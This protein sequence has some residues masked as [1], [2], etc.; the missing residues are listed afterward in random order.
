MQLPNAP[1]QTNTLQRSPLAGEVSLGDT[2]GATIDATLTENPTNSLQDVYALDKARAT[3]TER[4][5]RED[6]K[7][8]IEFGQ[9]ESPYVSITEQQRRLKDLNL[10][11]QLE[12]YEGE[13][14]AGFEMRVQWRQDEL[15]RQTVFK[16][17]SQGV[18]TTLASFGVGLAGSILDPLNIASGFIPV[19]GPARYAKML[20]Q[21][22]SAMGRAAVRARVGAL[23]G[24]VGGAVV[25]PL[26]IAGAD[27]RSADY[28]VYDS[29]AN[30][31]FGTIL[32]GGL[33][34]GGGFLSDTIEG[35]R[36]SASLDALPAEKRAEVL[37][38]GIAAVAEGRKPISAEAVARAAVQSD[39]KIRTRL[40]ERLAQATE[41]ETLKVAQ[42]LQEERI[43]L[44]TELEAAQTELRAVQEN[45]QTIASDAVKSQ[46]PEAFARLDV[47]DATLEADKDLTT[48]RSLTKS[49][50]KALVKERDE[51]RARIS[52]IGTSAQVKAVE[53]AIK[54]PTAKI[55][56][57]TE[58]LAD[59]DRRIQETMTKAATPA[60]GQPPPDTPEQ[61]V[62]LVEVGRQAADPSNKVFSDIERRYVEA[63]KALDSRKSDDLDAIRA[64]IDAAMQDLS[65]SLGV[66]PPAKPSPK[67][68]KIANDIERQ[69]VE[70]G[71]DPE[72]AKGE[73]A[74]HG[75][76]AHVLE[77]QYGVDPATVY[78]N[79]E[80]VQGVANDVVDK[81]LLAI[82]QSQIQD[83]S[84]R[85]LVSQGAIPAPEARDIMGLL[86]DR[87]A[88][89][90][91]PSVRLIKDRS[92]MVWA[93][94]AYTMTHDDIGEILGELIPN[95][96]R[97]EIDS[98][99]EFLRLKRAGDLSV[100]SQPNTFDQ[101]ANGTTPYA[102]DRITVDGIERTT[103]N[104]K[105]QPIAQTKEGLENFWKWFG[106][107]AVKDDAGKPLVVYHGSKSDIEI[108]E[109]SR[110]GEFGS[111][112]YF[113][114]F[115]PTAEMFGDMSRGDGGTTLYPAYISLK[116][117]LIT[118]DRNVPRGAGVKKLK[119]Q[120]YDGV[121]GIGPTGQKQY[122]VFDPEQ[123]K[124]IHNRGTFDPNDARILYQSKIE[125]DT[126]TFSADV[127]SF[128]RG[129]IAKD[130]MLRVGDTPDILQLAG[131]PNKP[132]RMSQKVARKVLA[133]TSQDSRHALRPETLSD[134]PKLLA[135]PLAVMTSRTRPDDS[136]VVLLD[137]T[138]MEGGQIVATIVDT[139][140][141][142]TINAV[143]SM[144][145]KKFSALV[146]ML[147]DQDA[148]IY[149]DME[150]ASA[151]FRQQGVQFPKQEVLTGSSPNMLT[152]PD[153]VNTVQFRQGETN[154]RGRIKFGDE[155]TVIQLFER[156]DASTV[157][158]ESAH[159][160]FEAMSG[161]AD[162]SPR[163][164]TDL[165]T[166][167]KFAGLKDGG[168]ITVDAHEK[169][170]RAF[171]AYMREGRAPTEELATVFARIRDWM[172][173]LYRSI[174]D[175]DI[176]LT[177]EV[178]GVF[179]RLLATDEQM[180]KNPLPTDLRAELDQADVNIGLIQAQNSARDRALACVMRAM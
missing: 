69:L 106:D 125:R 41:A 108:F 60:D 76:F 133:S 153:L 25:E 6:G 101:A 161:M 158:H 77:A 78:A 93:V 72:M 57:L 118:S 92:G 80:F 120:G 81:P 71:R 102:A 176:E 131:M 79:L 155:A 151:A 55:T 143:S 46:D 38:A 107:S 165:A 54:A 63:T 9:P 136:L 86:R 126:K 14:E 66:E 111:G 138:D 19:V 24:L 103:K 178:R 129:D 51:L 99:S 170:A 157:L 177:D 134:L 146:G 32:G 89:G 141:S 64:E 11:G 112:T 148:V 40:D 30:L 28:G 160:F 90:M 53:D 91:N 70:A 142:F 5:Y 31:V 98:V 67:V 144:Y 58:K 85:R 42:A 179:D 13:T 48:N 105:G 119:K 154:P 139:G 100:D 135:D 156:A 175:L 12:P 168:R 1:Y 117:P 22:G 128:M 104:S 37:S 172:V 164:A 49:S 39:P 140:D 96:R 110:G 162:V 132:L 18:G 26:V 167:R 43:T 122:V 35:R 123:I 137:A 52:G 15:K 45:E 17:S 23:E 84:Q 3:P 87:R 180:A 127:D 65:K 115:A 97:F 68:R 61:P 145:G 173:N 88:Q 74:I 33:H 163:M 109:P 20:D 36:F 166:L 121:I 29:V 73:A 147:S 62:D 7:R 2:L 82:N 16:N 34:A 124:S 94:D 159:F 47:V 113:S 50:R 44:A 21:A 116:N 169:V 56:E 83:A 152:K 10:D 59:V 130:R 150:R 114:D 75:A 27:T 95:E 4:R 149:A 174:M 8:K 171:E